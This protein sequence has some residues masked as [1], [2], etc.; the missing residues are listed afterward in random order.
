MTD[1]QRERVESLLCL[2]GGKE[3]HHGD[4][5]GAD[6]EA[7]VIAALAGYKVVVHPPED[8]KAR[9]F[10]FGDI[11]LAPLPYLQRN[12]E[13]VD[14][15]DVLIAVPDSEKNIKRGSGTWATVRYAVK[16]GKPVRIVLPDGL[17]QEW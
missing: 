12:H 5:I 16:V 17:V 8:A 6:E 15:T 11:M 3:F 14:V 4:C 10:T 1:A 9:A 13:I 7:G 2:L